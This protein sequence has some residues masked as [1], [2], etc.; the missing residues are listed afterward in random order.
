MAAPGLSPR[1]SIARKAEPSAPPLDPPV[2]AVPPPNKPIFGCPF[3]RCPIPF[4]TRLEGENGNLGAGGGSLFLL[5][6][7]RGFVFVERESNKFEQSGRRFLDHYYGLLCFFRLKSTRRF[8][9]CRRQ[10]LQIV[11][12]FHEVDRFC[13]NL[14]SADQLF[15][16]L[17]GLVKI[18][19]SVIIEIKI[20]FE[21]QQF[22]FSVTT[23]VAYRAL[24]D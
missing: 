15:E 13:E 1:P 20:G 7:F 3:S 18:I 8:A 19:S 11:C 14:Q 9:Q 2:P 6:R 21:I 24:D 10:D 5:G 16:H 12:N 22:F 4:I 23:Q 17:C